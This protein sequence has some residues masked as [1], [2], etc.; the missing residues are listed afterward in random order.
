MVACMVHAHWTPEKIVQALQRDAARRGR[1]PTRLEWANAPTRRQP[2]YNRRLRPTSETVATIMGSWSSA[3]AAAGLDPR[4]PGGQVRERCERH[5]EE[6][7]VRP[8]G[9]RECPS[10]RPRSAEQLERGDEAP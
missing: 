4:S 7:R 3:L 9:K 8:D 1:P 2:G 10:C 5:G 6:K